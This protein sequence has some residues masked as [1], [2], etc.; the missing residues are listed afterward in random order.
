MVASNE[1]SVID[2]K[3]SQMMTLATKL[4]QLKEATK[5]ANA[6][7]GGGGDSCGDEGAQ[8]GGDKFECVPGTTLWKWRTIKKEMSVVVNDLTC[9]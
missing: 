9:H 4:Q 6:T 1:Y 5:S 7:N 3:N 8:C 2:P